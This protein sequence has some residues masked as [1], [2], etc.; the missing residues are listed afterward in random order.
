MV[1]AISNISSYSDVYRVTDPIIFTNIINYCQMS[2]QI[3]F[4]INVC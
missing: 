2:K 4:V 1:L 3:I